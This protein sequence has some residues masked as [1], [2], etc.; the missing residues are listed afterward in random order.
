LIWIAK[1]QEEEKE[2][3]THKPIISAN[4]AAIVNSKY[5]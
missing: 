2:I 3:L 4:S 1:I 5:S